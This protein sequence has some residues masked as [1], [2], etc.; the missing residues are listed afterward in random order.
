MLYFKSSSLLVMLFFLFY[1]SPSQAQMQKEWEDMYGFSD[2]DDGVDITISD[3]GYSY[4]FGEVELSYN[5]YALIKYDKYGDT[6]W[7]STYSGGGSDSPED[8]ELLADSGHIYVTGR[9]YESATS[10]YDYTTIKYDTAGNMIWKQHYDT[11]NDEAKVISVDRMGNAYVTGDPG[12]NIVTVKYSYDGNKLWDIHYDS[13]STSSSEYVSDLAL[14]AQ[15]RVV[16]GGRI[17]F[18]NHYGGGHGHFVI[19]QYDSSG[20]KMWDDVYIGSTD[21]SDVLNDL[22]VDKEGNVYVGGSTHNGTDYDMLLVK[23]DSTGTIQWEKTYDSGVD[24][25]GHDVKIDGSNN[26]YISGNTDNTSNDDLVT[27]KYNSSGVQQWVNTFDK[28]DSTDDVRATLMEGED[29]YI[30]AESIDSNGYKSAIVVKYDTLGNQTGLLQ[31]TFM[32]RLRNM[33][34]HP[35]YGLQLTGEGWNGGNKDDIYTAKYCI[36]PSINALPEDT[37]AVCGSNVNL[38]ASGGELYRWSPSTGLSDTTVAA[39]TA[40]VDSNNI[41]YT[42]RGYDSAGCSS[43]DTTSI[44]INN[45]QPA[46]VVDSPRCNGDTTQFWDT[47]VVPP[48]DSI[49]AWD[50]SGDIS[51]TKENPEVELSNTVTNKV[52]LKVTNKYGCVYQTQQSFEV[53]GVFASIDYPNDRSLCVGEQLQ[54]QHQSSSY[55]STITNTYWT[56]SDGDTST[57]SSPFK[58]YDTAGYYYERQLRVTDNYGCVDSITQAVGITVHKYPDADFSHTNQGNYT[59]HVDASPSENCDGCHTYEWNIG[60]ATYNGETAQHTFNLS[61]NTVKTICLTVENKCTTSDT[62]KDVLITE[63]TGTGIKSLHTAPWV[64]IYPNPNSGIFHLRL[65]NE[66][67][68]PVTVTVLDVTG[69]AVYRKVIDEVRNNKQQHTIRLDNR[70][71][72]LYNV[73]VQ[74]KDAVRLQRIMVE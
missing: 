39:P 34:I 74:S 47:S 1:L 24:E 65:S 52:R 68:R 45:I 16:F 58:Q 54:F 70:A 6:V 27:I 28:A 64:D 36:P 22:E 14:T 30:G 23:Y 59:I 21:S 8:M 5:S 4:V 19:A 7:T 9:T 71:T 62:C 26:I 60:S 37:I 18:Q 43:L 73:K 55:N 61:S 57:Q 46:F 12:N 3:N 35:Q 33:S 32:E 67:E 29:L 31:N 63:N 41:T 11:L 48:E 66:V 10:S 44:S 38:N 2:Y 69:K 25:V 15:N 42:V 56:F 20:T 53:S 40:T 13:D 50:W 17:T 51:S 72:G 49:T